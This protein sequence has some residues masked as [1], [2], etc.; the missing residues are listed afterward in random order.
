M[1]TELEEAERLASKR[2]K[3]DKAKKERDQAQENERIKE[4]GRR[5]REQ[6]MEEVRKQLEREEA[7]TESSPEDEDEVPS[8]GASLRRYTLPP[9]YYL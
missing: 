5:L 9:R 8:L 1:Q 3:T 7:A 4:Q 2:Q 6:R